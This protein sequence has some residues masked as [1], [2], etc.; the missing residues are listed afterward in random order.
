[1]A[2]LDRTN[3]NKL[4]TSTLLTSFCL[5]IGSLVLLLLVMATRAAQSVGTI[6]GGVG[7]FRLFQITR[8][9]IPDGGYTGTVS[10]FGWSIA[11]YIAIWLVIGLVPA[12][13]RRRK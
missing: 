8:Q 11:A 4:L 7:P 9:P 5:A 2:V 10:Y 3:N 1:M 6:Q 13:I 12:Y